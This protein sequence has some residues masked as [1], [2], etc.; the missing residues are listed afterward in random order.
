MIFKYPK[1]V[2]YQ[3]PSKIILLAVFQA[4]EN[5]QKQKGRSSERPFFAPKFNV[6]A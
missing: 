5:P 6:S 1:H 2:H 3:T 4:L